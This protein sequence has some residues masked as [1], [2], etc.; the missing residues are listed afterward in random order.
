MEIKTI[1]QARKKGFYT[2]SYHNG[3]WKYEDK[4]RNCHLIKN[5]EEK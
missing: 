1:E 2:C 3:D 5:K 4:K